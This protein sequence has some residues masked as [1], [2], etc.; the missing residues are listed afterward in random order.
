MQNSTRLLTL[1]ILLVVG[2]TFRLPAQDRALNS[3]EI[4][5]QR[6]IQDPGLKHGQVGFVA[7]NLDNGRVIVEHHNYRALIPASIQK[8]VTTATVLKQHGPSYQFHTT[9]AHSGS[10]TAGT[11]QG[12]LYIIADGDPTLNSRY[13]SGDEHFQKIK[14]ALEE[15]GIKKIEGRLV[16]DLSIY[17]EHTTPDAWSWEDMGNYFGATP[18]GLMWNDNMIEVHLRSGQVGTDVVLAQPWPEYRP[19]SLEIDIQAAQGDKDDAWFFSAPKSDMI[20]GKGT[21]PAHKQDFVVKIS[22][23]D[24]VLTFGQDLV[25]ELKLGE[26]EIYISHSDLD[27]E[28]KTLLDIYSAPLETIAKVTN[29]QSVNLYAEALNILNDTHTHQKSVEGGV[30]AAMAQLKQWKVN[31]SGVR[32][33]DGSGISPMNR[34]TPQTMVELLGAIYRD[35]VYPAFYNSLP[36]GGESGT[37][38]WYFQSGKA[39]GNLRAKSGTMSGV[40][41]YAGYVKNKYDENVAFCIML[42]DYDESRRAEIMK[43]VERL[44]EAVIED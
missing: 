33:L 10:I 31:T 2:T 42:S 6:L 39:K 35:D 44:I 37:V 5:L 27:V 36:I 3:V 40:R 23:P 28:T 34:M 7:T 14:A 16:L 18:T 15:A 17:D 13:F 26:P 43:K 11:L 12:D 29:H 1:F 25:R 4:E 32:M 41:N 21:I 24:P 20:Y 9:L 8:V 22:N 38:K 30:Y 19:F